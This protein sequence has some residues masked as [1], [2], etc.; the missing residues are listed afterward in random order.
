MVQSS[1]SILMYSKLKYLLQKIKSLKKYLLKLKKILPHKKWK[2]D[3]S[4]NFMDGS[5]YKLWNYLLL[6]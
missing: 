5:N 4:G 6:K 3:K 2:K 1:S